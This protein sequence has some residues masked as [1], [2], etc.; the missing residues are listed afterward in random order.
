MTENLSF[1][2]DCC[3]ICCRTIGGISLLEQ[4]DRGDGVCCHLTD[5]NLCGIYN[6]RPEICNVEAMF[7]YFSDKMTKEEYFK[8]NTDSCMALKKMKKHTK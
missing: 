6:S 7:K 8:L 2:C 5:E 4:F 3:G 1:K